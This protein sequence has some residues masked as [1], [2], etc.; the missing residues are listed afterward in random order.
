[1]RQV[2]VR[3]KQWLEYWLYEKVVIATIPDETVIKELLM[4][5]EIEKAAR[6]MT[7]RIFDLFKA[8][9]ERGLVQTE[10]PISHA[11]RAEELKMIKDFRWL[12]KWIPVKRL[13]PHYNQWDVLK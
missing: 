8:R 6:F 3:G 4:Q 13:Y 12:G 1:M 7:D 9:G 10:M 5:G 2:V 11:L